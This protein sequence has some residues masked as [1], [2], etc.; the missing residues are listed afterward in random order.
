M[1]LPR[2]SRSTHPILLAVRNRPFL[3]F[4]VP[5][6]SIIVFASFGLKALTQTKYDLHNQKNTTL[7]TEQ[8]LGMD[9][10]RKKFDI[11][12][13]YYRL[14]NPS[15][16]SSN[17]RLDASKSSSQSSTS[18]S[19][20]QSVESEMRQGENDP[21]NKQERS[22]ERKN[23]KMTISQEEYEPIRV[24]RPAG[25]SEW[26]SVGGLE[27]APLKGYRKEDRWV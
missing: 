12:E 10:E 21:V 6:V 25:V 14:N 26:G 23:K 19:G 18:S 13:E 24:P 11:R 3:L 8:A 7:T 27:E 2:K 4:G 9:K 1:S 15:A 17:A 5:F 22:S 16:L 20:L